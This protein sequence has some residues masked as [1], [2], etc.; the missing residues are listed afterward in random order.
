MNTQ[1]L[2]LLSET[3]VLQSMLPQP[4]AQ[5]YVIDNFFSLDVIQKQTTTKIV[6]Q[7]HYNQVNTRTIP[8]IIQLLEDHLPNVL[9]TQCFNDE[10]YP[11]HV[12]VKNTEIGHLFEHI[13]LE[14]LCQLKIAKGAISAS[15]SGRTKWNWIR[16]PRGKFHIHLTCGMKDA[17]ILPTAI[18]KTVTL[19][20][21][22]LANHQ[23]PLFYTKP[24]L[25]PKNGLKNGSRSRD[26]AK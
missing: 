6:M 5:E 25:N 7:L 22:I 12:E 10:G 23:T 16:D 17:D 24:L 20:K 3:Q 18:E 9:F 15:Y 11:F 21:V 14:Y 4:A 1:A 19:M 13:L 2:P 26:V 8:T